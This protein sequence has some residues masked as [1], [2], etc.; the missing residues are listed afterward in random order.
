MLL[1]DLWCVRAQLGVTDVFLYQIE[2]LTER[3]CY[4]NICRTDL[5]AD[6]QNGSGIRNVVFIDYLPII[7]G[8]PSLP[9]YLALG[10]SQRDRLMPFQGYLRESG[11]NVLGEN[12]N[13]IHES[14][15]PRQ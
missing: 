8:M 10:V 9:C 1:L 2:T 12:L 3:I 15:F 6:R 13:S 5:L 11:G 14:Q 7:A 4:E